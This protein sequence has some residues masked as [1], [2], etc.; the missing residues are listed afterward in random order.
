MTSSVRGSD[1]FDTATLTAWMNS[2]WHSVI[3][4]RGWG[5]TYTNPNG[6]PMRVSV[7]LVAT[8]AS[9][10]L[11]LAIDVTGADGSNQVQRGKIG[12]T[13]SNTDRV[14][15][16]AEVP[17]YGSYVVSRYNSGSASAWLEKY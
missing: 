2:E 11:D 9:Q 14:Y 5:I 3:G 10:T 7:V 6:Y 13:S 4:E 17:P 15:V 1:N 16:Q 8:A 12:V